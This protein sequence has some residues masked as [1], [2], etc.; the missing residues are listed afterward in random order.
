[1]AFGIF[2]HVKVSGVCVALPT[3]CYDTKSIAGDMSEKALK[4][5]IKSTGVENRYY[6]VAGQTSS[7]LCYVAAEKIFAEF[8]IEKR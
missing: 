5:F 7:D 4:R 3:H 6:A 2:N 8:N 1:M